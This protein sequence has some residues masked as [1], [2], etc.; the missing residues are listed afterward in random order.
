MI[1]IKGGRLIDPANGTDKVGV[2]YISGGKIA[3]EADV[4]GRQGV[5]IEAKGKLVVPGLIDM[6]VHLR[7]PGQEYKETIASGCEA[8][9]HGGFTTI[10][11]MPNTSP[12][13]DNAAVVDYILGRAKKANGVNVYP[14]GA[15]SKGLLGEELAEMADMIRTG[16]VAITDDGKGVMN[17]AVMR[18]AFEY[19][20]NFK[21]VVCSHPEDRHLAAGGCMHEGEMS[22]RLGLPGAP[23]LAESVIVARD[24]M[25]CEYANS[26]YHVQHISTKESIEL[27]R[28]A[29]K[30]GVAV[31]CEA[32]PHHW[33]LTDQK[34]VAYDSN[35][36]MN[37]PLRSEEHVKAMRRAMKDGTID[38]IATDHAPHTVLE[39]DVEFDQAANGI[40][41]LETALPLAMDLVR[42]GVL[43]LPSLVAKLTVNPARILGLAKGTLSVGADAD[44]TVIDPDMEWT[45]SEDQVRSKSRNS[46]WLNA[47]LIGRAVYTI[48]GGKIVHQL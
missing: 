9:A 11:S 46:P 34:L 4:K 39:K 14:M 19:A 29:K 3:S 16:A 32:A 10:V 13:C 42:E 30:R 5:V 41:G 20:R 18:S 15:I 7:E 12:V 37:P 23:S 26:R 47:R 22:T 35:Y 27:V 24:I 44:V 1:T 36:K 43:D 28:Q 8:A 45:Y 6:H 33:A 31:T 25:L 40:I 38:A 17:A 2:L 48:A 21:L